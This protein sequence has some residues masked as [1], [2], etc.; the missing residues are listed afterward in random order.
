MR[1]GSLYWYL[2]REREKNLPRGAVAVPWQYGKHSDAVAGEE[3]DL[4]CKEMFERR[5]KEAK[6]RFVCNSLY[7]PPV[8]TP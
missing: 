2:S 8:S 4:R 6:A 7:A 3:N 1:D 5:K